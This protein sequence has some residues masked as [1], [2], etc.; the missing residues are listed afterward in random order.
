[1]YYIVTKLVNGLT[2]VA[3]MDAVNAEQYVK[4]TLTQPYPP[5]MEVEHIIKGVEVNYQELKFV[6]EVD[7]VIRSNS[8]R[9]ESS[10][11]IPD[12]TIVH[13]R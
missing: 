6:A 10:C 12:D 3:E 11:T 9:G 5:H 1:M 4:R 8:N 7:K 13:D 2:F